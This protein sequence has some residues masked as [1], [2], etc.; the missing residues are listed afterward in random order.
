V[1]KIPLGIPD[2]EPSFNLL[3]LNLLY[4]RSFQASLKIHAQ[5]LYPLFFLNYRM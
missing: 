1:A 3:W 4:A 5:V 2:L